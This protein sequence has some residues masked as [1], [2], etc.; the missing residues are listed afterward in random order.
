[1]TDDHRLRLAGS[2][3]HKLDLSGANRHDRHSGFRLIVEQIAPAIAL[4]DRMTRLHGTAAAAP[5]DRRFAEATTDAVA[6]VAKVQL[7]GAW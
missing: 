7:T 2:T 6:A 4:K 5:Q 3:R 1:M